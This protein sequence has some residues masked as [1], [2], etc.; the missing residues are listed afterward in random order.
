MMSRFAVSA[1]AAFAALSAAAYGDVQVTFRGRLRKDGGA[2]SAQSVPMTFR[3]YKGKGDATASWTKQVASV[4]VD[5]SG[6]FQVALRGDGL[7]SAIDAGNAN[8]IGVAVDGGKEQYPRQALLANSWSEKSE[9]AD[10]LTASPTVGTASVQG[11]EAKSLAVKSIALGGKVVLPASTSPASMS[12]N[13]TKSWYTLEAKGNV[14][15]FD[16]ANPR[17]LGTKRT[18]GGG[19]TF[20]TADCNCVAFFVSESSDAMPGMSLFVRKGDTI[21]LPSGARLSD[22]TVVRCR[23]YPIGVK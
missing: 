11:V 7:A 23:I 8:W 17:D 4:P 16:G 2:P 20:S 3:L 13:L 6:L 1:I 12:V 21:F 5:A 14:R 15:F 9:R 22:G 19:C 10:R 18:S